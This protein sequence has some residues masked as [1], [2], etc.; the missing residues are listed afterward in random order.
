MIVDVMTPDEIDE[1]F[2]N[3][4]GMM[5]TPGIIIMDCPKC[6]GVIVVWEDGA[7]RCASCGY[8]PIR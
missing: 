6:L 7:R 2:D 1:S 3:L 8:E 5:N 4:D